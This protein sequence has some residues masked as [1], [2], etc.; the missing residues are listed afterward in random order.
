MTESVAVVVDGLPQEQH[1]YGMARG[2]SP[3]AEKV[4]ALDFDGTIVPWGPLMGDKDPEPG[5]VDA[6]RALKAAG[7][8]IVIFTSRLSLTWARSVVGGGAAAADFLVKQEQYVRETLD[9]A[10]I[11]YDR[12]T[13]EKVPAEFYIDDN[14]YRYEGDWRTVH[15]TA[16][17][18]AKGGLFY[19]YHAN[20]GKRVH[21]VEDIYLQVIY[22]N[23]N[24]HN[25]FNSY[26]WY[27]PGREPKGW[28]VDSEPKTRIYIG[29]MCGRG[30][31]E[32]GWQG[33][34]KDALIARAI[35]L[36]RLIKTAVQPACFHCVTS[37]QEPYA[38]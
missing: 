13:A 11:P 18:N 30:G 24:P 26:G 31:F 7:Y 1:D 23:P 17:A 38:A 3:V 5:A 15:K 28:T 6:I 32:Y 25:Y 37:R 2:Y 9:R 22:R 34:T 10:G 14:A 12:I 29:W 16:I 8:T 20:R 4:A 35:E 19:V 36:G 21:R 27:E 33:E